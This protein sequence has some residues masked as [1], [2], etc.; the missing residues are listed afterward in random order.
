[1]A[2]QEKYNVRRF[3]TLA[4]IGGAGYRTLG[5]LASRPSRRW[6]RLRVMS[7]KQHSG[8]SSPLEFWLCRGYPCGPYWKGFRVFFI[9]SQMKPKEIKLDPADF[10]F[11]GEIE[12]I[13]KTVYRNWMESWLKNLKW[14]NSMLMLV[15]YDPSFEELF[16]APVVTSPRLKTLRSL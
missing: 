10:H 11:D 14:Y 2:I 9:L 5:S 13:E 8:Q 15:A 6:E 7:E 16:S 1:M 12:I 4:R 3:S